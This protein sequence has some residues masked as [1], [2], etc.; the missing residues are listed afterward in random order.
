M[1]DKSVKNGAPDETEKSAGGGNNNKF[2]W[3]VLAVMVVMCVAVGVLSSVLTAYFMRRGTTPPVINTEGVHQALEGVVTARKSNIVEVSCNGGGIVGSGVVTKYEKSHYY[4]LTNAHVAGE[5]CV[6]AAVRFDGDDGYYEAELVGYNSFYDVSVLR[7]AYAD[8][9]IADI[10]GSGVFNRGLDYKEGEYVVAIGN[11]MGMG[12]AAYEGIIS[13]AC[14]LL[15]YG[16]KTVPVLR[17]TAAINAGMSGG[18]VFDVDGNFVGLGTYRMS[19]SEANGGDHST[20]VENTAFVVPVSVVYPI[21]KQIVEFGD[22]GE[23]G[24]MQ[25]DFRRAASSAVGWMG[26]HSLGFD[27]VYKNG[28]LTVENTN[29]S[30]LQSGDVIT[31]VGAYSVSTD[32]CRTAGE[33]LCYRLGS[34][35]GGQLRLTVTRNGS[36]ITVPF[37]RYYGY[38]I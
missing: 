11:A 37:E 3:I 6:K 19:N 4:V 32:I 22:G 34:H 7:V 31:G 17:T 13:R 21:Y 15:E 29:V 1:D 12:V 18:A 23:I 25:L 2:V 26:F 33:F 10:D 20:D 27:C 28:K 24:I 30:A 35:T 36:E 14:E 16:G 5:G 38:A 8:A 9:R